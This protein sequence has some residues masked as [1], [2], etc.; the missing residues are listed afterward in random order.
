LGAEQSAALEREDEGIQR[1]AR[2]LT[3]DRRENPG[4][5]LIEEN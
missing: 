4:T 5:L 2:R 1:T 3:A